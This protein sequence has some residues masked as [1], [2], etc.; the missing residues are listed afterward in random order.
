MSE[1]PKLTKEDIEKC[2][3][4]PIHEACLMLKV[5]TKEL[6]KICREFD[7]KRWPKTRKKTEKG[8]A[9]QDFSVERKPNITVPKKKKETT[10]LPKILNNPQPELKKSESNIL[11]QFNVEY[12]KN[13][14][15]AKPRDVQ[16]LEDVAEEDQKRILEL[17]KQWVEKS[18]NG[19]K[20]EELKDKEETVIQTEKKSPGSPKQDKEKEQPK[21]SSKSEV[22]SIKEL[23]N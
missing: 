11:P 9:F 18:E 17:D 21:K 19:S 23:L 8:A 16:T 5:E 15:A 20:M 10:I 12:N 13:K 3:G 6:Q 2:F 1:K 4:Y 7:I 14:V 22:M